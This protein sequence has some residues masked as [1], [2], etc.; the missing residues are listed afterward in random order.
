[1]RVRACVDGDNPFLAAGTEVR[2]HEFHY[3]RLHGDDAAPDTVM[4]VCRGVGTGGGRD[5]IRVGNVVATYT[6]IHALGTPEWAGG[7][8]RAAEE[9]AR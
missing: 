7:L 5:G 8:V 6:H 9:G 2:G 3:S 4:R 1:M